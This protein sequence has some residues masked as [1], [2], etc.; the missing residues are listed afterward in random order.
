MPVSGKGAS[1]W[2]KATVTC[3]IASY[4]YGHLGAH[5]IESALD[6]DVRQ[7][8]QIYFVDDGRGDCRFLGELYSNY[9]QVKFL[10]RSKNL[11][12]VANFQDLLS[13]VKTDY[14]MFLGAD[15]W[16]A[17]HT[18]KLLC[19]SGP[20][21]A[22]I[23]T[24][25]ISVVG[26][27]KHEIRRHYAKDMEEKWFGEHWRRNGGHHG[28]MLYN[29]KMAKDCGGYAH[30]GGPYSEEDRVLFGRMVKAGARRRHVS[31]PLLFYR[32]H[33]RNINRYG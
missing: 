27:R 7:F 32:R 6:Q 12:V 17:P 28:S 33:E 30:C 14:V 3:V 19:P 13:N 2:D 4:G 29:V 21:D 8:D 20:V 23:V 15:N 9:R 18:L 31:V 24:Y 16:L 10:F 26:P 25:D 1:N 5:A 11:G 22:D